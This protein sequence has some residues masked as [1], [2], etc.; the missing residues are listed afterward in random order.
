M[1]ANE[2]VAHHRCC[3]M[4]FLHPLGQILV[5]CNERQQLVAEKRNR[6]AS[7]AQNQPAGHSCHWGFALYSRQ[8][9]IGKAKS[10]C[11]ALIA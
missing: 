2:V 4:D 5:F 3:F 8:A 11:S 10:Y 1:E 9:L 7:E 6:L